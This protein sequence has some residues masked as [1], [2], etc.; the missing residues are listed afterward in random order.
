[1]CVYTFTQSS[2]Q[3][4][5]ICWTRMTCLT[6]PA[7]RLLL[8]LSGLDRS[9]W[10]RTAFRNKLFYASHLL[11]MSVSAD[12]ASA[13]HST[14]SATSVSG[15]E[16]LTVLAA[17]GHYPDGDDF[18]MSVLLMGEWHEPALSELPENSVNSIEIMQ[19]AVYTSLHSNNP[20]CVDIYLENQIT[21]GQ[22]YED[23][24][25]SQ[26]P[27]V[28]PRQQL[29]R[30]STLVNMWDKLFPCIPDASETFFKRDR[31]S[32]V[33]GTKGVRV[34]NWDTRPHQ[35]GALDMRPG[36]S[37]MWDQFVKK[38]WKP[39][40]E[41][42]PAMDLL[43]W[44]RWSM[45]MDWA[46]DFTG[47]DWPPSVLHTMQHNMFGG[48]RDWMD[49]YMVVH[50]RLA[51]RIR[52]RAHKLG[53]DKAKWVAA[54][55]VEAGRQIMS[56]ES[57]TLQRVEVEASNFYLLL[58]MLSPN[59]PRPGS[60]CA[61]M[62]G[63]RT[64]RCCIVYAGEAHTHSIHRALTLMMM[65]RAIDPAASHDILVQDGWKLA[66]MRNVQVNGETNIVFN[67]GQL[68][69]TLGIEPRDARPTPPPHRPWP[70][71][72]PPAGPAPHRPTKA[73]KSP[74]KATKS[75]TKAKKSPAKAKKSPA[76]ATKSPTKATKS[77]TKATK[78]PTKAKKSPAKAKKSPAK[79]N[80]SPA[81]ANKSPA[82]AKKSPAKAKK[83]PVK[84]K[85]SPV[86]AKK[87]PARPVRKS[88]RTKR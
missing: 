30:Q 82:K 56:A 28:L 22:V 87:S 70:A 73:K 60:P 34:H 42:L 59:A 67:G 11:T 88:P 80:K 29:A 58:R 62:I 10:S 27:P 66:L 2:Q 24:I 20:R 32:C 61:K 74:I 37:E 6:S 49:K 31:Q 43:R 86:K 57:P 51:A 78:R 76:K 85:K 46:G 47:A 83:S 68:L 45:G 39:V 38:R 23:G 72:P 65:G 40:D 84:A 16:T 81:K 21:R 50:D 69:A 1:V 53:V 79:A 63:N 26:A 52:K 15:P 54:R 12:L 5:F 33:L 14:A 8:G 3:F 17:D 71:G 7:Q 18:G 36:A 41:L 75:P 19:A 55:V 77:P 35:S 13:A 25:F 64:P 48:N 9:S 44:F 4:M